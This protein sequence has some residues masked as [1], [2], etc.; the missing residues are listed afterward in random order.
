MGL[1][2][3]GGAVR[4]VAEL[5]LAQFR[6]KE[7]TGTCQPLCQER[8]HGLRLLAEEQLRGAETWNR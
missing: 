4:V 8:W 5:G 2:D 3:N 7:S 6:L 1:C